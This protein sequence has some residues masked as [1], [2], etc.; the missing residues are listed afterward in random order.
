M[1]RAL[2][3]CLSEPKGRQ[4]GISCF[5]EKEGRKK[6]A[7]DA[8]KLGSVLSDCRMR[9]GRRSEVFLQNAENEWVEKEVW[10]GRGREDKASFRV[11]G[12]S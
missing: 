10:Y 7:E 1:A 8:S 2:L 5:W 6:A 11:D 4:E 3:E 9:D 12:A